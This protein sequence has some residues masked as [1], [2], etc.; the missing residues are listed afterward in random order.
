MRNILGYTTEILTIERNDDLNGVSEG[1]SCEDVVCDK[2]EG[3]Y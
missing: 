2:T 1:G 3:D